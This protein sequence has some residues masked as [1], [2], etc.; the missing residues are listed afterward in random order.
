MIVSAQRSQ[1]GLE[2]LVQ[3]IGGLMSQVVQLPAHPGEPSFPIYSSL[4]GDVNR[5][6]KPYSRLT[7]LDANSLNGAGGALE[8]ELGRVRAIA[9]G[10]E[11]YA[12]CVFDERQFLWATGEELGDEAL[13]LD[14]V[15]RCSA[16]EL[17]HPRCPLL[18]PD[19]R[20]PIRWVR[21]VSL[22]DARPVWVPAVMVYLKLSALGSGEWFHLPISTGCAAHVT[23]EQALLG[24]VCEVIERDSISLTWLQR[25]ELPR[26]ELD[27][28]PAWLDEYV[29]RGSRGAESVETMFFD[30]TTE[31][32][33]PTIYSL[34]LSPRNET[35][36]AMVMCSAELDPAAAV[37]KILRESASSRIAMQQPNPTPDSWDDFIDVFHGAAYMGRPARLPAFD[38]LRNSAGRR[39]LSEMPSAATGD[40]RRDLAEILRRLR[41]RGMEAFAVD[42]TTDEALRAGMRVVRVIIP[43]LQP[44]TF[45]YRA[46]YL[47][48]P[49]LYEAPE[50][51]GFRA[52]PEA[53]INPWPQPFA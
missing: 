31:L 30:A 52:R 27:V 34:Q 25:L 2:S 3:P 40:A 18:A 28:T 48:H 23:L 22:F 49:R 19:K 42:L 24:G 11:R 29:E 4:L 5:V 41:A 8:P 46:R 6:L 43:A 35:L 39:R 20:A 36:A 13:D 32:G 21:G 44:L 38:F 1:A 37:A 50:L 7:E 47:G 12:S 14:T 10:L 9:E 45:S 51:M 33:V 15:P 16:A 53:E 26:V 17:A